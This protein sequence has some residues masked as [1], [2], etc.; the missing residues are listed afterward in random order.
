MARV[1]TSG[2]SQIVPRHSGRV[3]LQVSPEPGVARSAGAAFGAI[4][5]AFSS[6]NK[7]FRPVAAKEAQDKGAQEAIE[8]IR[9]NRFKAR[10]PYTIRS[11]AYNEASERITGARVRT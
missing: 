9:E 4:A 5:G 3:H 8:D 10:K 7:F 11:R 2:N 1:S 6:I